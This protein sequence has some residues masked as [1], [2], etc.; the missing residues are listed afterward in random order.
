MISIGI[1]GHRYLAEVDKLTAGINEALD[2]IERVFG[3]PTFRVISSLAEGADR[4][5]VR[6]ILE[7]QGA[8]LVAVLPLPES[9]YLADFTTPET[10]TKFLSLFNQAEEIIHIQ[11]APTREEAYARAG[12]Y[13]LENC[14]VVLFIWDG[15]DSQGL[16]G[17]GDVVAAAR[18]QNM[19]L[20]WIKA[21]NRKPG[22]T[23]PTSLGI[24]QG[25]VVY[26]NFPEIPG[27]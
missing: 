2:T 11:P 8:K 1:A 21:G 14:D 15:L 9:D 4:L 7:R 20:V 17:T 10:K 24:N 6:L 16:G 3:D 5:A 13:L 23:E 18:V 22:T 25:T 19:P 26:E 27:S 12:T